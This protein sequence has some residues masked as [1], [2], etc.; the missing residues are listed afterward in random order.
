MSTNWLNVIQ[1]GIDSAVVS[2]GYPTSGT[3]TDAPAFSQRVETAVNS[4]SA[5][6][7]YS[8]STD[9]IAQTMTFTITRPDSTT[10]P[11]ALLTRSTDASSPANGRLVQSEL[12]YGASS[13]A[14][15][16]L[17]YANDEGASPQVQS[18][19]SYDDAGA[20]IKIDF[21]HDA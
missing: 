18:V 7:N 6:Y 16:V 3:L 4:P 9:T 15:S 12:K 20:P 2:F 14:K 21:D 13:L 1:N 10:A 11:T 5:V 8:T 17:A 19:T